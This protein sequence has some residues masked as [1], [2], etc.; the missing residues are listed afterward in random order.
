MGQQAARTKPTPQQAAPSARPIFPPTM[1]PTERQRA[2]WHGLNDYVSERGAM[3]TS[4]P[5]ARPIRLEVPLESPLPDKL[6]AMGWET[7]FKESLT[8]IG[9][10]ETTTVGGKRP[11]PATGYAF[12]MV[13]VFEL[14]MPRR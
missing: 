7:V 1:P 9:P 2:I 3:I 13:N 6:R 8:R 11:R 5:Y 4:I 10:P 12:R 14:R